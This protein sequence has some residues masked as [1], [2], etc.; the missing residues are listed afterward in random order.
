MDSVIDRPTL[1]LPLSEVDPIR[2][3]HGQWWRRALPG[4]ID[5]SDGGLYQRFRHV[6][7]LPE[8]WMDA[9]GLMLEPSMLSPEEI[10][11]A[12]WVPQTGPSWHSQVAFNVLFPN[13]RIPFIRGIMGC[14]LRVSTIAETIW[15]RPYLPEGWYRLPDQG[16]RPRW[17][18]LDKLVEFLEFIKARYAPDRC[19]LSPDYIACGMGDLFVE[20]LGTGQAY[21]EFHDHPEEV[22]RLIE[23]ITDAWIKQLEVQF[24]VV[25]QIDAGTVNQ[26]GIWSVGSFV[27]FSEDRSINLSPAQFRE[28]LQPSMQRVLDR[29]D[30]NIVHTHSGGDLPEWIVDMPGLTA[31]EMGLDPSGPTVEELIPRLNRLLERVP[32]IF[33][34]SVR[35]SELAMLKERVR[36]GGFWIDVSRVPDDAV[37]TDYS[38]FEK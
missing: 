3:L 36:P 6:P 7:P 20:M 5:N 13:H 31:I 1:S 23:R 11:P 35:E 33:V 19:V 37:I 27:K 2:R 16:F 34:G 22:K 17:D 8:Q 29:F 38:W 10:Q 28:F 25:P 15:P 14:G 4:H 26:Y 30:A 32:M 9:D 24:Q 18:W 12:P 21:L